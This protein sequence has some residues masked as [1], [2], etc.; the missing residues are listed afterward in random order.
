MKGYLIATVPG[1]GFVCVSIG[2]P[3]ILPFPARMSFWIGVVLILSPIVILLY[4]KRVRTKA[5]DKTESLYESSILHEINQKILA[6]WCSGWGKIYDH[7]NRIVLFEYPPQSEVRYLLYFEFDVFTKEGQ[8][9]SESFTQGMWDCEHFPI[10]ELDRFRSVYKKHPNT[11][12][13]IKEW[14]FTGNIKG[15]N[16]EMQKGFPSIEIYRKNAKNP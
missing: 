11:L 12:D 13:F 7:L 14:S 4:S 6:E 15:G 2:L 3:Y 10:D 16:A 1:F 9:Q 8:R 5:K